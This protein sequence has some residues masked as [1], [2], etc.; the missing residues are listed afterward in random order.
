MTIRR[1]HII[2]EGRV[3]GV[4]FRQSLKD[5]AESARVSGWV[6]NLIGGEVEA[7]IEGEASAVED[8]IDWCQHGPPPAAV[9]HVS[10]T[11]Q[12]PKGDLSGFVIK[13]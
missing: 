1:A 5:V 4:Y 3:Q 13:R 11:W 6:R 7:V 8:V 10:V 2:V 12:P 9:D